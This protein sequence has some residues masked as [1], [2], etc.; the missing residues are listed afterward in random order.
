MER[1]KEKWVEMMKVFIN[2]VCI[3]IM[4]LKDNVVSRDVKL[5]DFQFR[6]F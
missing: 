2:W 3:R 4:W 6:L 5:R 1:I